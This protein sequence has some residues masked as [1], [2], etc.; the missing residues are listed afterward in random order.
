[1]LT[2]FERV[3]DTLGQFN[4]SLTAFNDTILDTRGIPPIAGFEVLT[5]VW[6]RV[7]RDRGQRITS[8]PLHVAL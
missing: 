6:H 8:A 3:S 1:M 5:A 7:R 4:T 2:V